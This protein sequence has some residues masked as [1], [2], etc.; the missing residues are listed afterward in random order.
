MSLKKTASS[1]KSKP[2]KAE[3]VAPPVTR[4]VGRPSDYRPE[5]CEAL[6]EHMSKGL[7][8]ES[9][10]ADLSVNRRT[11]YGWLQ[12]YPEFLHAKEEGEF[13]GLAFWEKAGVNGAFGNHKIDYRFWNRF[14][15]C[16]FAKFGWNPER[17]QVTFQENDGGF[18]FS[19]DDEQ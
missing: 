19:D 7:S 4:P 15:L 11:L 1:R 3:L 2:P 10:A 17:H 5:F 12:K 18:E 16:R 13:R 9:F 6:I 8:F 14:M